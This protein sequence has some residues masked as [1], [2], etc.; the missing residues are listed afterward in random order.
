[1][2]DLSGGPKGRGARGWLNSPEVYNTRRSRITNQFLIRFSSGCRRVNPPGRGIDEKSSPRSAP[3]HTHTVNIYTFAYIHFRRFT[4]NLFR[5]SVNSYFK[6]VTKL[7]HIQI[8]ISQV[9]EFA[10]F[11]YFPELLKNIPFAK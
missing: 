3:T 4:K 5:V 8:N 2:L 6:R 1:M 7:Q 9:L 11:F 10:D